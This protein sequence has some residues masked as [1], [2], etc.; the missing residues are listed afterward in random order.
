MLGGFGG[1]ASRGGGIMGEWVIGTIVED[2]VGTTIETHG[3]TPT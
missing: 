1:L 2:D 3:L